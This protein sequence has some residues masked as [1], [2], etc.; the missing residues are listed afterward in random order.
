MA[1]ATGSVPRSRSLRRRLVLGI[2]GAAALAAV[3]E[4]LLL[5][6][7]WSAYEERLVDRI[8]IDQL[9]R[10]VEIHALDP[11]LAYP[12]TN[13]LRL[14]VASRDP[15]V[16]GDVLPPYLRPLLDAS[17][18]DDPYIAVVS[19]WRDTAYH[20]GVAHRGVRT[21][22]LAYDT[23]EHE[24]RRDNLLWALTGIVLLLTALAAWLA[25]VLVDRL[26][27]GVSG[28][29]RMIA[30]GPG[31]AS[32]VQPGMDIEIEALARALDAH[33]QEVAATLRKERAF[34]AAA[35]HELRSPL[36]RIVTGAQVMLAQA[37]LPP[38]IG[39][40]LKTI[41]DAADGLQR[42]LD[43]L[44][45]VAR[46]QPGTALT[47]SEPVRPI[48]EVVARCVAQ[49]G[50]EARLLGVP[51]EVALEN[52]Q[53]PLT[54][55]GLF[56]IVLSNLLRNAIRHGRGAPVAI[57]MQG[58]VVEVIDAGPGIDPAAIEQVFDPFWRGA[59]PAQNQGPSGL[60]LGLTIAERV[61]AAAGWGLALHSAPA[62]G[63]RAR[64]TLAG[65]R[66]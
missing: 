23:H 6:W 60:G 49:L 9:L 26:L 14:Y 38:T 11:A 39:A 34:A 25:V 54:H 45:Q 43:V 28:L 29:Q 33:R 17:K 1:M 18:G 57:R 35:S 42:L 5:H 51:I 47:P 32:F 15:A 3:C 10:S 8:V 21:F 50:A 13:D 48:G 46:W 24:R 53:L 37:D 40:R 56:E 41:L 4:A 36:T 22:L 62:R 7:V 52:P 59:S 66:S 44:L 61:C 20:V 31:T 55:P 64:V 65:S 19:D 27:G 30:R 63:T 12:N 58:S 16:S 2:T